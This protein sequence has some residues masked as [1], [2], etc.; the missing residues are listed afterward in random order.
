MT[1]L[2]PARPIEGIADSLGKEIGLVNRAKGVVRLP[3]R[4]QARDHDPLHEA[5]AVGDKRLE[6]VGHAIVRK[7]VGHYL[8]HRKHSAPERRQRPLVIGHHV[9]RVAGVRLMGNQALVGEFVQVVLVS[10]L[11]VSTHYHRALSNTK[12]P[13]REFQSA[14]LA[15]QL[16]HHIRAAPGQS[17]NRLHRIL[18]IN[19]EGV[20]GA[21]LPGQFQAPG[22]D[23]HRDQ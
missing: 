9:R 5:L 2:V 12:K 3:L 20:R 13:R 14:R 10:I 7:A 19:A 21:D 23:I 8:L 15:G 1:E 17:F 16:H 6:P 18:P 22:D 11:V 4:L